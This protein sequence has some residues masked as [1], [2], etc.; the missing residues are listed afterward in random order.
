MGRIDLVRGLLVCFT[1][2]VL[3]GCHTWIFQPVKKNIQGKWQKTPIDENLPAEIWEFTGSEVIIYKEDTVLNA[4]REVYRAP[5]TIKFKL[6]K[7][8]LVAAL[9][10]FE[11]VVMD[12]YIVK[13]TKKYLYLAIY[14]NESYNIYPGN[15][16]H[17]FVRYNGEINVVP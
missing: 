14:R 16:Q 8:I 10:P 11:G 3:L 4:F 2:A 9:P 17:G 13:L 1:V 12:W 6:N 5:Y 7:H 15:F